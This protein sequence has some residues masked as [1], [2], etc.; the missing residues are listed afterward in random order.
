MLPSHQGETARSQP[1]H[2]NGG[3]A[4]S[5]GSASELAIPAGSAADVASGKF[6]STLNGQTKASS[7]ES[8]GPLDSAE[9]VHTAFDVTIALTDTTMCIGHV[10]E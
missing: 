6:S 4:A 2:N 10:A 9:L 5:C 7:A 1:L 3:T 8:L